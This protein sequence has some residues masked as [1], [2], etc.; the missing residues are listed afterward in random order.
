MTRRTGQFVAALSWAGALSA[1]AL[2][3]LN[4]DLFWH[5]SAGR[6]MFEHLAFARADWLSHTMFGEPWFD[7]EWLVQVLWY[8][9][10]RF[11]G[12][13]GLWALKLLVYAACAAVLW[14]VLGLYRL[15]PPAKALGVFVWALAVSP[16]NDLR[17]ENFSLLFFLILW[18]GLEARRLNRLNKISPKW[19]LGGTALFFALWANLHAGFLYGLILLG[20]YAV[21]EIA[22]RRCRDLAI[23]SLVAAVAA[24][25][26]PY[27]VQ[28]Y[29]V[30]LL[31][32]RDMGDLEVY[33]RE[34]QGASILSAWLLPY[35]TVLAAAY[36]A[37]LIRYLKRRDV[38]YEHI[39]ALLLLSLSA[40]AH[41]RTGAYFLCAAVPV[42]ASALSDFRMLERRR[43][44]ALSLI[45]G[46]LCASWGFFAWRIAGPLAQRRFFRSDFVPV[47]AAEFLHRKRAA[48]GGRT[49]FNP[50]HWGGYLGW[51]LHPDFRVFV[52]G[53][54]LFHGLLRPIYEAPR[55]PE[56]YSSFLSE[57]GIE[58]AVLE[59][60]LQGYQVPVPLKAGGKRVLRRPFYLS[61]LPRERWALTYWDRKALVFVRRGNFSKG[62]LAA[63][64]FVHF[65]ADDLEAAA[66]K[67]REGRV[68][69]RKLSAEVE[70][71]AAMSEPGLAGS[72]RA[73]LAGLGAGGR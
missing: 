70:R 20:L 68:S 2:P 23:A 59:R 26:N 21:V 25:V 28:V 29:V 38:P 37:V 24:L 42:I 52:D 9:V 69:F 33:I 36:A 39:G 48:L 61:Y 53:R 63:N 13:G 3:I 54:Y 31:H 57:Y 49:L 50:W 41:I 10:H 43:W 66:L 46:T 58:I 67:L 14:K 6:W 1:F 35:W 18:G 22:Q 19:L 44:T 34:W 32:W 64:E 5:L 65:R 72:A 62:W 71:F 27:G 12:L 4:P 11:A 51:R 8:A 73:W 17:P 60:V 47:G 30:P 15:G 55:T 40:T 45:A 56:S 7:F 16:S